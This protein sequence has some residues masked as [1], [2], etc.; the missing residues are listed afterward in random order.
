MR[1]RLEK[2]KLKLSILNGMLIYLIYIEERFDIDIFL[3]LWGM[4]LIL[5]LMLYIVC[6]Y[7]DLRI[8]NIKCL[9]YNMFI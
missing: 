5:G 3:F 8:F 1:F 9:K 6:I 2:K 7:V 4:F